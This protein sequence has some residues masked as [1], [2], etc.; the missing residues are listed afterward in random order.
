MPEMSKADGQTNCEEWT[1]EG[2]T[3]LGLLNISGMPRNENHRLID[4]KPVRS[5]LPASAS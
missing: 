5:N 1:E 3:F 2:V 4:R